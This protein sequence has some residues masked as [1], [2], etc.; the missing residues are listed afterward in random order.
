MTKHLLLVVSLLSAGIANASSLKLPA[1][2]IV[3]RG[4]LLLNQDA[5]VRYQPWVLNNLPHPGQIGLLMLMPGRSSSREVLAPLEQALKAAAYDHRRVVS[6]SIVN[7]DDAT[8]G[9]G[10][11]VQ[12]QL[13]KEKTA[14][15]DVHLIVDES[16]QARR[17]LGL[18]KGLVHV[19]V[20]GCDGQVLRHY[21]GEFS[22]SQVKDILDEL[23]Q[24]LLNPPCSPSVE[25]SQ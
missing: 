2:S 22:A 8:W 11:F 19:M 14:E 20:Y 13:A 7:L 15:P 24:G 21:Q 1:I 25:P 9:A 10:M 17:A 4:E 3:D 5:T 12:G 18:K 16:G 6:V 23:N